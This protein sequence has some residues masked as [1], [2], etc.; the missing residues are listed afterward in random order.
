VRKSHYSSSIVALTTLICL[1][2]NNNPTEPEKEANVILEGVITVQKGIGSWVQYLGKVKN[3]GNGKAKWIRITF[4]TYDKDNKLTAVDTG[5]P[6]PSP[7][8]PGEVALFD[9]QTTVEWEKYDHYEYR[10]TWED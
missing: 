2:C 1:S 5:Y 3:V 4:E 9:V 7:L 10:I 8:D 6:S